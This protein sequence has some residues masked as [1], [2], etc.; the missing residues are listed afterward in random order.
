MIIP[1]FHHDSYYTEKL[2]KII[3]EAQKT[4]YEKAREPLQEEIRKLSKKIMEKELQI[5]AY[6]QLINEIISNIKDDYIELIVDYNL[7]QVQVYNASSLCNP[8][9]IKVKK[10]NVPLKENLRNNIYQR[11]YEILE[12]HREK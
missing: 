10:I 11:Y 7:P 2:D 3:K 5:E 1:V 9:E 6:Q 4:E 12:K 8:E